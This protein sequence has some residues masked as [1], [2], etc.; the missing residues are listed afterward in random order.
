[1]RLPNI[2]LKSWLLLLLMLPLA[3]A[4]R[5]QNHENVF[6]GGKVFFVDGDCYSRMTRVKMVMEHPF[7]P[8]HRH[9]F[10]NYPDGVK[11]HT[12]AP[13]DYL[14][15]A[16]AL[17]L[18]PWSA[19]PVDVAGAL[20][21]P[22]LGCATLLFLWF[23]AIR[24]R[25]RHAA[26][27][28][29]LVAISPILVHGTALGRPDHQSLLI[30]L[31]AIG[32]GCEW[33]TA[34]ADYLGACALNPQTGL[35]S[36]CGFV[37]WCGTRPHLVSGIIWG[38][39]LWV[40]FYEP[41]IL[42]LTVAAAHLI[43]S[44]RSLLTPGRWAWLMAFSIPLLLMLIIEGSPFAIPDRADLQAFA[45]WKHSV[46]ELSSVSPFS[47]LLFQWTGLMLFAA[48]LL[49]FW[50]IRRT[51]SANR[52][53]RSPMAGALLLL[54]VVYLLTLW[55]VRWG[56]FLALVFAMTLPWQL[57]S[58]QKRWLIWALFVIS[59]WP[60]LREWDQRLFPDEARAERL[61]SQRSESFLLR[62]MAERLRSP[63]LTPVLA[64]W[65]M[66]PSVAY[67]SG[68]P[69]IAGSS[70][71]SLPGI[72][73]TA[74]FYRSTDPLSALKILKDRGVKWVVV[75]E[76]TEILE[77]SR[78]LASGAAPGDGSTDRDAMVVGLYEHPHTSPEFLRLQEANALFKA[79]RVV[80]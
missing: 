59:L 77:S 24:M 18:K 12:T 40:S 61:A 1:M 54:V 64:P 4:A 15:A 10:E 69:T 32:I 49:L 19:F 45:V 6:V 23:W 66:C 72:M 74:R 80:K 60:V 52:A 51:S 56:Y 17:A 14:I 71:E 53:R 78:A 62:E 7:E 37:C 11:A 55:Q 9:S 63:E 39:S 67:W 73:D 48:P 75:C 44:R 20:I 29:L 79:F 70:H 34:Q 76:P 28:L 27:M 38:A 22:L 25:L 3:F 41:L 16:L 33:M 42:L 57:Q 2:T 47:P 65:W 68:Q 13:M 21:S 36:R 8:I 43:F 35:G 31:L 26:P 46:G 5:W 50:G 30:F 58:L